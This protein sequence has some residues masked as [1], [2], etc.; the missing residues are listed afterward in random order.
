M[1]DMYANILQQWNQIRD[2]NNAEE[3]RPLDFQMCDNLND[4]VMECVA[5]IG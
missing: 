5:K 1:A 2:R 3:V 4:L